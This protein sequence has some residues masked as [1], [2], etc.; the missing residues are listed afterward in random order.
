MSVRL[1]RNFQA[2]NSLYQASPGERK[3]ILRKAPTDLILAICEIAL[4]LL[5]GNIPLTAQQ[6]R[7]LKRRKKTIKL[8]ANKRTTVESKRKAVN[9]SGG[10]LHPLLSVAVP[11]ISSLIASR[12]R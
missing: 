11:F 5:R 8:F 1:K 6:Y 3:V 10:F 12:Q 9:Q 4:N 2:L 7:Q